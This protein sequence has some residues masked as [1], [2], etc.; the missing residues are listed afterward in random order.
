MNAIKKIKQ[1]GWL[2]SIAILFNRIVPERLFRM[3]RFVVYRMA[4]PEVSND[5]SAGQPVD[6]TDTSSIS[7][8]RSVDEADI[9]AV[10]QMTYFQRSYTTGNSIAYAAKLDGRLAAGMWAATTC[11]DENEL[12]VRIQLNENQAWLFAALVS[13][14]YRRRGLYSKLL[15]FTIADM[16]K[17][18]YIDQ[19]VSVNPDNIGSNRIHQRLSQETTG[20]VLAIRFLKTTCCWTWGKISKDATISWNSTTKPIEIRCQPAQICQT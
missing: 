15:H 18:G 7:I 6:S 12:G 5:H 19:L 3:R 20:H 16:A 13:K 4:V 9:A 1:T 2:Y 14:E 11:F 10:E 17:Q 8:S